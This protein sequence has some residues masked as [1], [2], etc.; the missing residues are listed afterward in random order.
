[1]GKLKGFAFSKDRIALGGIVRR[2]MVRS[3]CWAGVLT[4]FMA[5]W[6]GGFVYRKF[7]AI[8]NTPIFRETIF[9]TLATALSVGIIAVVLISIS[10]A[11]FIRS[12]VGPI[13]EIGRTTRKIALGDFGAHIDQTYGDEVG[14]LCDTINYMARRLGDAERMKND[15][16]SSVSHELRTP[17]TAIK[18]WAETLQMSDELDFEMKKRGL[19]VIV[20]E[21][22]RLCG[23]VEE[24]LDFSNMQSGRI[25]LHLEK[26][27][28]LAEISEAVYMFVDRARCENKT[29]S[30]FEPELLAPVLGDK[31]RLRQVFVNVLDNALKY[32][33]AEGAVTVRAWQKSGFIHVEVS[34]NGCGIPAMHLPRVKHK[35]YKANTTQNGSGIGL[36]V[37]NEIVL[38]HAGILEIKSEENV[39]TVV[40]IS[41]PA[42]PQEDA[43]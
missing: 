40:D 1:M 7:Y 37:A 33:P 2:W 19:S 5:A 21:S 8:S 9:W 6:F 31:N 23:I 30:Y 41:F 15:F 20:H 24:L 42:A 38:L 34:D 14:E 13:H 25:M 22:E 27:D 29:L 39:G 36:A 18:G 35:F 17:L 26:I 12:V 11:Y 28:I 4:I 10:G 32:T 43:G 3:L 16:I